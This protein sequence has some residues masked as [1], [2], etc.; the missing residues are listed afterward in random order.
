MG[1]RASLTRRSY[2]PRKAT[3]VQGK[4]HGLSTASEAEYMFARSFWSETPD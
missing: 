4:F 2:T 3:D 1:Q